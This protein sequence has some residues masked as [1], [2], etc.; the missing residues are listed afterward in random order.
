MISLEEIL[1]RNYDV[2]NAFDG[3]GNMTLEGEKAYEKMISLM[4]DLGD[5]FEVNLDNWISRLDEVA[6]PSVK[7]ELE[8]D[9]LIKG[10]PS[11]YFYDKNTDEGFITD[12]LNKHKIYDMECYEDSGDLYLMEGET[13]WKN[14]EIFE[15]F[16]EEIFVVDPEKGIELLT[17]ED[18]ERFFKLRDKYHSRDTDIIADRAIDAYEAMDHAFFIDHVEN[19][20]AQIEQVNKDSE[21]LEKAYKTTE[22]IIRR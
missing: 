19:A 5:F 22:Q 10:P 3:D 8:K 7:I 20:E 2:K 18:E 6:G 13:V 12:L 11:I 1:Q 15:L 14:T 16:C 4:A 21:R 9:N 17:A